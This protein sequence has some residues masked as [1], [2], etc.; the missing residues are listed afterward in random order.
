M[1][2]TYYILYLT[3]AFFVQLFQFGSQTGY[4]T[5]T[6]AHQ[7]PALAASITATASGSIPHVSVGYC[8]QGQHTVTFTNQGTGNPVQS[9][10][11]DLAPGIALGPNFTLQHNGF[12]INGLRVAGVDLAAV[13]TSNPLHGNPQFSTDPDGAGGLSDSDGDGFF[14]DLAL[15][16]KV[17]VTVFFEMDCS[18]ASTAAAD[19]T[20]DLATF[21]SARMGFLDADG[22]SQLYELPNFL[23]PSNTASELEF[24][25]DP[26]AYIAVDTFE[27]YLQQTRTLRFFQGC[28]GGQLVARIA[29]PAGIQAV[30]GSSFL[31]KNGNVA[32]PT[33]SSQVVGDTF[34]LAFDAQATNFLSGEYDLRLAFV[35]DC[36]VPNGPTIFPVSFG[37]FCPSCACTHLWFCG[38][39]AGPQ[40]H[41]LSPPCQPS[42]LL[43]CANGL[44]TIDFEVN[45]TTFGFA[46]ASFNTPFDANLANKK[47]ALSCDSV[48]MRI[49]SVVG[50]SAISDSIGFV[51]EYGNVVGTSAD[52]I[53]LFGNGNV[54]F[55]HNGMDFTCPVTASDLTVASVLGKKTLRFNL[56]DC[57]AGL[58]FSLDPGDT[59]AFL[60]NFYLNPDG[61]F[62]Q[63]FGKVP[64]LR[65]NAFATINGQDAACDH[66]G[67][68]FSVAKTGAIFD[69]P[70]GLTDNPVGCDGGELQYRLFVPDND[71]SSFF[72]TELRAATKVDSIVFDFDP[73]LLSAFDGGTV[74]VSIP[75]HPV[76]GDSYFAVRPLSD[77]PDGHYV[78]LFDT[79]NYVP[80]LNNV[81]SYVF[82]LKISLLPTCAS[83]TGSA[84]GDN[85]YPI[86]AAIAYDDRYYARFIGDGS[87]AVNTTQLAQSTVFYTQ[88][89]TL[90]L[91]PLTPANVTVNGGTAVWE[92]LLCNSSASANAGFS[93]FSVVDP[94][95][96]VGVLSIENIT[97]PGSPVNLPLQVSGQSVFVM[98][99]ALGSNSCV[100]LRVTAGLNNCSDASFQVKTGWNCTAF[101]PGW[102]PAQYPPCPEVSLNLGVTNQ[103]TSP[104]QLAVG[105][106]ESTCNDDGTESLTATVALSSTT[107][108]PNDTYTITFL[109]DLNSDG[110]AQL[111]D[112][113]VFQM[114]V[115][116]AVSSSNPL[117]INPLF[118]LLPSQACR[119]LLRLEANAVDLCG[120]VLAPVAVPVL[121]NAGA[122]LAVCGT[123]MPV[124]LGLGNAACGP[125]GYQFTWSSLPVGAAAGLNNLNLPDP[126]LTLD[127]AAFAGQTI[128]FFLKTVRIDCGVETTDTVLVSV[129][130]ANGLFPDPVLSLQS[131]DCQTP[132]PFCTGISPLIFPNFQFTD[133]GQPFAGGFTTCAGNSIALQLMPGSHTLI[134]TDT[135]ADCADTVLVNVGCTSTETVSVSLLINSADTVC[136]SSTEL[137]GEITS[138]SNI[139]LDDQFV[140]YQL[141]ND[142]CILITGQ[143][144]GQETACFV[145][146]DGAGFCD[147]TFVVSNVSHP[148]ASGI[149]DSIVL[150]QT[151]VFCFDPQ[152]LNLTGPVVSM[153]D[154]CPANN[155]QAAS[156]SFDA[157]NAC[158]EYTGQALGSSSACVAF[159]DGTGQCDTIDFQVVVLP[160]NVVQDTIYLFHEMDTFCWSPNLLPGNLV[161]VSDLCPAANGEN[162]AFS[163]FGNCIAYDG[164]SL[165][166]DTACYR[167]EDNLGNVVLVEI[168][169]TVIKTISETIC[170]TIFV[171]QTKNICLDTTELRTGWDQT[172]FREICP[173]VR[174]GNAQFIL[175]DPINCVTY[176][177]VAP[178][179]DSTCVVVCD[180][181]GICDTTY[182]CILVKPFFDPPIANPDTALTFRESPVVIDFLANDSI[183]G[184]IEDLYILTPP[185]SGTAILN[186]DNSFTYV[187]TTPYCARWDEFSY[188]AC[189][190][191]GCDTATVS[192]YIECIELTIFSAVSPNNDGINDFFYVAKIEDL[193]DNQLWVYNRWGNLVFE[194]KAYDNS[195]PGTYGSDTDLPDGTYYYILEWVENGETFKQRGYF[196]LFR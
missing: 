36:S 195:W 120:D 55:A 196:E 108:L 177:G 25:A 75:G 185:I 61:P 19:C 186:L 95:G 184:G 178:G 78:A 180:S 63:Q 183:F 33:L 92:V 16:A 130:S 2:K 114:T 34:V 107:T 31:L 1:T 125:A 56:H 68:L 15:G 90:T 140:D 176:Q 18:Q 81:Q 171:G 162:V 181:L 167:F 169:V 191:N 156:F 3:A 115:S 37:H 50:E 44:Q 29:L 109:D 134:A 172:Q 12:I 133:N 116:G 102:T 80:S 40:L 87:C 67:D 20:N 149:L 117:I 190:P 66:F 24:Y 42:D 32:I 182:F 155:G 192:I 124:D 69:F 23:A 126:V 9:L 163:T 79:L 70:N 173:D 72:G 86:N 60:G 118:A 85:I 94:S 93:W 154:A 104:V 148:Y 14:D 57:L 119:L 88:P 11:R 187:P 13:Q 131:V 111:S 45:R 58:G 152:L 127:P 54:R 174:T 113:S 136:F 96:T 49:V 84:S 89:P 189:N 99:G 105:A 97:N 82:D 39:L 30:A 135:L 35:S 175:P 128:Q 41:A 157:A 53:F 179:K 158:V 164:L 27:L 193:P 144:V 17:E 64:S 146:C 43:A 170:D 5:E 194:M 122:D 188:V 65:A 98:P 62:L 165:G 166:T 112:T 74:T 159:C 46:D 150:T 76:Y 4:G 110:A 138:L 52:E 28:T 106:V 160:G 141:L 101:G 121:R 71:F 132:A 137:G 103:G 7:L 142:S 123:G 47:V 161:S 151:Q 21:L 100:R 26:D 143:M 48:E 51:V 10:A 77:F 168:A 8:S 129:A 6:K 83:P 73:G 22:A 153:T 38:E 59:V 147:T 145:A 139:C 91:L